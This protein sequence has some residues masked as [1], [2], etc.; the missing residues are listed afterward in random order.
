M[1]RIIDPGVP[2]NVG[3]D[4][5]GSG[6]YDGRYEQQVV[7]TRKIRSRVRET[8]SRPAVPGTTQALLVLTVSPKRVEARRIAAEYLFLTDF[9]LFCGH[10]RDA[11]VVVPEDTRNLEASSPPVPSPPLNSRLDSSLSLPT[12]HYL[13][14]PHKYVP[15][16][17]LMKDSRLV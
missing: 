13:D 3:A 16:I 1:F 2:P 9:K 4:G 5:A 14:S 17:H 12:S 11:H 10:R 7:R 15:I 8:P 6:R